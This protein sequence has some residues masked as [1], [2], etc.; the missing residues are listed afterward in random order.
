VTAGDRTLVGVEAQEKAR[1][2][3]QIAVDALNWTVLYRDPASG[4][5]WKESYPWPET[6]GGGPPKLEVISRR[7]ALLEFDIREEDL[8]SDTR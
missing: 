6:H 3:D 8:G 5:L 7:R 2:L 4:L 1:A